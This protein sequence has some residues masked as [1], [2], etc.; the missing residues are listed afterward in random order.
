MRR[1]PYVKP[2]VVSY[3]HVKDIVQGS[4]GTMNDFRGGNTSRMCWIAEAVYGEGD[5]RTL[6][7]RGWLTRVHDERRRWWGLVSL[8]RLSGRKVAGF[9]RSGRL[10]RAPFVRL[11]DR[12][13]VLA[14]D[15]TARLLLRSSYSSQS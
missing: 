11:F 6:L 10:P 9:I 13:L 15:D 1:K 3:G 12:L 4:G 7:L 14:S 2:Q 5:P 8:Y